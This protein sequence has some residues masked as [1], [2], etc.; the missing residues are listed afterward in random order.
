MLNRE[1][2]F[3]K[4]DIERAE[5]DIENIEKSL[6]NEALR[7]RLNNESI[8]NKKEALNSLNSQELSF[9]KESEENRIEA[10][11][12]SNEIDLIISKNE[13]KLLEISEVT[14]NITS[15][16]A[17]KQEIS[18][19]KDS[20]DELISQNE[21]K[22]K[23]LLNKK[24]ELIKLSSDIINSLNTQKNSLEGYELK[25]TSRKRKAE[26]VRQNYEKAALDAAEEARRAK[27]LEDLERSYEGFANSVKAVMRESERKYLKG[28]LGPVTKIISTKSDYAAAIETALSASIQNVVTETEQDAKKRHQLFKE[29]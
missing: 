17:L 23:E 8:L 25:I 21:N 20:L 4:A 24:E 27:I 7:L 2:E 10:E 1:I 29:E 5:K 6:E 26:E 19:R 16:E 13:K 14:S 3:I 15:L 28:I 11:K 9:S 22:E 12:I 18:S